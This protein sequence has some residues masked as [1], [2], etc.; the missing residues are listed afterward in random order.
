[1]RLKVL[2]EYLTYQI[3]ESGRKASF[4]VIDYV[5]DGHTA[6]PVHESC[7][8]ESLTYGGMPYVLLEE[9]ERLLFHVL[10][11]AVAISFVQTVRRYCTVHLRHHLSTYERVGVHAVEIID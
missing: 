2:V 6:F 9:L 4:I 7:E 3:P 11:V 5:I 10:D 1:M 8:Q